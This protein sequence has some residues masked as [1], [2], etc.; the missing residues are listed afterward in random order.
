M[1]NWNS[2]WD[3]VNGVWLGGTPNS[4][5]GLFNS[6]TN[7]GKAL[8]DDD[9]VRGNDNANVIFGNNGDDFLRGDGGDDS[10]NGGNG[11][12]IL[13]G[14]ELN[15][16]P[17]GDDL[18]DG[19][20]GQDM[21]VGA[22]GDDELYGGGDND[23]LLGNDGHDELNGEDGHD[24][25]VG[26]NGNDFANGGDGNDILTGNL[27]DD[28]LVG[29]D[30]DDLI[31]G[32]RHEDTLY[33]QGG[34]DALCGNSG[35]DYLHGGD[36]EDYL[37]GGS[38][39]DTLR[40]GNDDDVMIGGAD[41]DN[42][43]GENGNDIIFG[44]STIPGLHGGGVDNIM[45]GSGDD[46]IDGGDGGDKIQG[47][48][49]ADCIE[50]GAGDDKIW[51][52][53]ADGQSGGGEASDLINGGSGDDTI[54]GGH[55]DDQI[56]GGTGND[57]ILG[58]TGNDTMR[59]DSGSDTIRGEDG[60]DHISGDDGNDALLGGNGNDIMSGGDGRD[61]MRG[62]AGD[63]CM[64][65][66][67]DDD[68]MS[69][70]SGNDSMR[71]DQGAD[72][73]HGQHGNDH[74]SGGTGSDTLKGGTGEDTL[75]GGSGRDDLFGG[76]GADAMV[77]GAG[78]D[79]L[80]GGSGGD[81]FIVGHGIDYDNDGECDEQFLSVG[82]DTITDF[83]ED[84]GDYITIHSD[85][86]GI[87]GANL[88]ASISGDDV[89]ITIDSTG[90]TIT[91]TGLVSELE[92]IDP[93]DVF[94]DNDML[95]A[96]LLKTGQFAN[97]G[98]GIIEIGDY[99]F[100]DYACHPDLPETG[101]SV[102][103]LD[104]APAIVPLLNERVGNTSVHTNQQ[105]MAA[106]YVE[107]DA[108]IQNLG[109]ALFFDICASNPPT[110]DATDPVDFIEDLDASNQQLLQ[111]GTI[112]FDDID[113]TDTIALSHEVNQAPVWSAGFSLDVIDPALSQ[114]LIDGFSFPETVDVDPPGVVPWTY[115]LT[116]DFDFLALGETITWSY[117]I[118]II[119]SEGTPNQDTITFTIVGTNDIPTVEVQNNGVL[120]ETLFLEDSDASAQILD[121]LL[122][123]AHDDPDFTDTL[124]ALVESNDD[125]SWSGGV[126]DPGLAAQLNSGGGYDGAFANNQ[127]TPGTI[128]GFFDIGP[129]DL[130]FLREGETLDWSYTVTVT[131]PHGATDT[132]QAVF[133]IVGTNDRPEAEDLAFT[134]S[135]DD[136]SAP[137]DDAVNV[138]G[139]EA[140]TGTPLTE[141]FVYTDDDVNDQH[142]VEIVGLTEISP[143][144]YQ[145]IDNEGFAYGQLTNNG[146]GTFT[147][148][149]LDDFQHLTAEES[150]TVTF[151]YQVRDD[152]GVGESPTAPSESELSALQTVTL[153]IEGEDDANQV[154]EDTLLFTTADQS[155]WNTGEAFTLEPDLPFLG[156]DTGPLSLDATIIPDIN[157]A[158]DDVL[159]VLNGLINAGEI[160]VETLC[161]IF[162]L[163]LADCDVDFGSVDNIV[164]PGVFTTGSLD[165]KVGIQPYFFLDGGT[166]GAEVPVDV[167]FT[168][169]RQVEQG[170][171][172]T[173]GSAFTVDDGATFTT[174]GPS[175]QFGLDFVFD[176][177]ANLALDALGSIIPLFDFNSADYVGT[178]ELG[179]PGFNI[180]DVSPGDTFEIGLPLGSELD[181]SNPDF[182]V[183][184]TPQNPPSNTQLE[185]EDTEELVDLT[186]DIDSLISTLTPLPPLGG[187]DEF[188]ISQSFGELGTVNLA[189]FEYQWDLFD[190]DLQ[191]I[192]SGIQDF[193]MEITDLPLM[194][195]LEDGSV[196]NGFSVGD[197][198]I[199]DVPEGSDFDVDTDG[200]GDGLMDFD[201]AIDMEA[202]FENVTELGLDMNLIL[203][204]LRFTA[205][206]SSDF[207]AD[208]DISLFDA[209]S[210]EFD[211]G[212]IPSLPFDP[213]PDDGFLIGGT[214]PL[215]EDATLATLF[216]QAFDVDGWNQE[217]TGFEFDVA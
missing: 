38:G 20:A 62:G 21:L 175:V 84:D 107:D 104:P 202:V 76:S 111:Q 163:G 200:D 24:A 184:G 98:K 60:D 177:V 22:G 123:V 73:I 39:D 193:A 210:D 64:A 19:E 135:E 158:S 15:D 79:T 139:Y 150:R 178:G 7:K 41:D 197:N 130:D 172:I 137:V 78:D 134:L 189:T 215:I 58:G 8:G 214:I 46:T 77:A 32:G 97:D 171:Q 30:G 86:A 205:G 102:R 80:R 185:G 144:V 161:D 117:D 195:V 105:D 208:L 53:N 190:I 169:P 5:N 4:D 103:F 106:I 110:V 48:D 199:V 91:V 14:D 109:D 140:L 162:T 159:D 51:G 129:M 132:D 145:T 131:D 9:H 72:W 66:N 44:D 120:G 89:I 142:T 204:F 146:D 141:S 165:A 113:E 203:G 40:G 3:S 164:I 61:Q 6:T 211:F 207:A 63:D 133:Q 92:G 186:I 128:F 151:Q 112:S 122:E 82:D 216:D 57:A 99:C 206:F 121:T 149:P 59:G 180:F 108:N 23:I 35:H 55:D 167:V 174:S 13:L 114:M 75:L 42:L 188:S 83:D 212:L 115:D 124:D 194:A 81:N 10:L 43:L 31:S 166:L 2:I 213:D 126:I 12:D 127:D 67:R 33:G 68:R 157:L 154:E 54:F 69:G 70:Q 201:V 88:S 138:N 85:L 25:L 148:D 147:F 152:S 28:F 45:G 36:G 17:Q 96:F 11:N 93:D 37:R 27:G 136:S 1:P 94:F 87:A 181:V 183:T 156:F 125:A 168:A 196:I 160:V 191:G 101:W 49:N 71:G 155:I 95:M 153:T 179:E 182:G 192:L 29:G 118:N 209:G 34:M 116:G 16:D 100:G 170:E 198:I 26:G 47:G 187:G 173:I 74:L 143:G 50:G 65:G 56:E 217:T 18:L 119:D 90:D 176:V 52:D